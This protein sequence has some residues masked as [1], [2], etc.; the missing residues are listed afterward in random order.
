MNPLVAQILPQSTLPPL[1][2]SQRIALDKA[3]KYAME[4]SIKDVLMKQT[5]K[6]QQTKMTSMQVMRF[7]LF[8]TKQTMFDIKL[9]VFQSSAQKQQA[10]VIMCRVYVGSIYYDIDHHMIRDAFTPF[11]TIKSLDMSYDPITGKHKGYCFIDFEI[12][13]AAHLAAEQMATRPLSLGIKLTLMPLLYLLFLFSKPIVFPTGRTI[14]VGRPSNIGQVTAIMEQLATEANR[15]NSAPQAWST[16]PPS[17]PTLRRMIYGR[18][19]LLPTYIFM[20][21]CNLLMAYMQ[22]SLIFAPPST[23]YET[24]QASM[25]A[26]SSMNM[27]DLGGQYL[28]VG[29][30]IT[31][32]S[33]HFELLSAPSSGTSTLPPAAALAAAAVTSK[34]MAQEAAHPHRAATNAA[35]ALLPQPAAVLA[36][37]KPGVVTG[38]TPVGAGGNLFLQQQQPPSNKLTQVNGKEILPTTAHTLSQQEGNMNISGSSQRHFLMQK[39]MRKVESTVMVLRNM[40]EVEDVDDDLE[41]EITEECGKFGCVKRVVIYQEKQGEEDGAPVIVKIFVEFSTEGECENAVTSLNNR[42]FGGKK[43]T[44]NLYPQ[45]LYAANDLTG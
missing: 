25:D 30:A 32:P 37:N 1:T 31:P 35:P 34:I 45:E 7:V 41:A 39:L 19:L 18:F 4:Q 16:F 14:K 33:T 3:K 27:F 6:H 38:V 28:R 29:K 40:V 20:L 22:S 11:G 23:E 26:I 15:F 36:A 13:E 42:W 24:L 43:V 8:S 10:L 12:P 21:V 2:P 9:F 17:T 44:A 5:I